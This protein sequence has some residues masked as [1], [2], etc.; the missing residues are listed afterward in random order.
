MKIFLNI[1]ILLFPF[2]CYTQ[3]SLQIIKHYENGWVYEKYWVSLPDS[4]KDGSYE[5][6]ARNGNKWV[7][8]FFQNNIRSRIWEFYEPFEFPFGLTYKFDY[9]NNKLLFSGYENGDIFNEFIGGRSELDWCMSNIIFDNL[10][11]LKKLKGKESLTIYLYF[12]QPGTPD[13]IYIVPDTLWFSGVLQDHSKSIEISNI[14]I[15]RF[16]NFEKQ[17]HESISLIKNEILKM[18]VW[19]KDNSL[20][21]ENWTIKK[22]VTFKSK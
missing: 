3:D 18:P 8:G 16:K 1:S 13:S 7:H 12:S 9:S 17:N 6:Y 21:K 20:I 5:R 14:P 11:T 15:W 4:A 19:Y 22:L 10:D 2:Y